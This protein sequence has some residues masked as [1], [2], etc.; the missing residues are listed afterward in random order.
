MKSLEIQQLISF[1]RQQEGETSFQET[2]I[3]QVLLTPKYVYKIPKAVQL[4]YL[5]FRSLAQRK[6]YCQEEIRLNRRLTDGIYL[7]AVSISD[8]DGQMAIGGKEGSV[9][10]YA[11]KM[12]RLPQERLMTNLLLNNAVEARQVMAIADQLVPFHR[13]AEKVDQPPN[14]P[15]M[16]EDFADLL[17]VRQEVEELLGTAPARRL[18]E[19]V[20]ATRAFLLRSET[21]IHERYQQQFTIEIHGDL[22]AANIFLLD[23]PVIFD[24]IAFNKAFRQADVLSE[25]AFFCMD[26]DSYDRSDLGNAFL[27]RYLLQMPCIETAEDQALFLF[28]K[29]YR[30]NIRLKVNAMKWR[31]STDAT[32]KK[33]RGNAVGNYYRLM[34]SYGRGLFL[35]ADGTY[36]TKVVKL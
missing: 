7:E 25:L 28:Y 15:L 30:A 13:K 35:A 5:D 10:D 20:G 18:E 11:V 31:Q 36:V 17:S 2:H 19:W 8:L 21:R 16:Q 24:C 6:A 12:K 14:I 3:S 9:I 22:H 1:L 23:Q 27:Q 4:P 34:K 26:M 33:E 29:L 32:E